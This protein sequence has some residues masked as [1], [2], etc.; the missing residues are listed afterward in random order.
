MD[1]FSSARLLSSS[2]YHNTCFRYLRIEWELD[3]LVGTPITLNFDSSE[4]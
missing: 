2:V 3:R 4:L 1:E